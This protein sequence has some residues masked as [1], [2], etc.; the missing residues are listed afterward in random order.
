MAFPWKAYVVY[1]EG[2]GIPWTYHGNHGFHMNFPWCATMAMVFH[3]ISRRAERPPKVGNI[4][5]WVHRF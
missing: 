1:M 4:R 5:G 3:R 2:H